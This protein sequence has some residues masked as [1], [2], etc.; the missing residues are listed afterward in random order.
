MLE[1]DGFSKEPLFSSADHW[2]TDPAGLW[3]LH[4][5]QCVSRITNLQN[6]LY[7][8]NVFLYWLMHIYRLFKPYT[9]RN[10]CLYVLY[11][12]FHFKYYDNLKTWNHWK[13][14]FQRIR[15][16]VHP[17]GHDFLRWGVRFLLCHP[18]FDDRFGLQSAD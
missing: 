17:E 13:F 9:M 4:S 11:I 12:A 14:K 2:S 6:G 10:Q 15:F 16:K 1:N 5:S 18:C 3:I 7:Y 8:F